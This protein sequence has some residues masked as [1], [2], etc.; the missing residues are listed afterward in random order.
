MIFPLS[1][2]ITGPIGDDDLSSLGSANGSIS[3]SELDY[4]GN[5]LNGEDQ[6]VNENSVVRVPA[7]VWVTLISIN[8]VCIISRLVYM[9]VHVLRMM[10]ACGF[11]SN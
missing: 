1:N 2:R 6:S 4:C 11:Y 8:A 9:Y 5:E 7:K 3:S 10:H